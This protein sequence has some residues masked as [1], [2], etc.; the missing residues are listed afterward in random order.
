MMLVLVSVLVLLLKTRSTT[1]AAQR[2]QSV[3]F[4]RWLERTQQRREQ[5]HLC[6]L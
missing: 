6:R 3:D 4:V 5:S 2:I 1:A